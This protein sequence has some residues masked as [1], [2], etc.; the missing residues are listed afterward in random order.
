MK[1]DVKTFEI[2]E[3]YREKMKYQQSPQ[4]FTRGLVLFSIV[5][6]VF[7]FF[8][9]FWGVTFTPQLDNQNDNIISIKKVD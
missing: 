6:A 2:Q 8:Y 7:I 1:K 5:V 9:Y 4:L 3:A